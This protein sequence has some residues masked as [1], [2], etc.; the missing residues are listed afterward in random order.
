MEDFL[1]SAKIPESILMSYFTRY[2]KRLVKFWQR[3]KKWEVDSASKLWEQ[4]G[5]SENTV[6]KNLCSLRM[7]KGAGCEK[8]YT[9]L[10]ET[11]KILELPYC[12][13]LFGLEK[14]LDYLTE[15][16]LILSYIGLRLP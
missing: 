9:N 5:K 15:V 7:L 14:C 3:R 1:Y 16:T 12:T 6:F 10:F 2:L 13:R 4:S 11:W 8:V